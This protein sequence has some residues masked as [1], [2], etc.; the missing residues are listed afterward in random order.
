MGSKNDEDQG[1]DFLK[2]MRALEIISELGRECLGLVENLSLEENEFLKRR[3]QL[4]R[5]A[6]SPTF[7]RNIS[8]HRTRLDY[9]GQPAKLGNIKGIPQLG[10]AWLKKWRQRKEIRAIGTRIVDVHIVTFDEGNEIAGDVTYLQSHQYR[11]TSLFEL[12][13]FV[14]DNP[15]LVGHNDVLITLEEVTTGEGPKQR[16][17]MYAHCINR[18][19][20]DELIYKMHDLRTLLEKQGK[21]E[22]PPLLHYVVM[23]AEDENNA[24]SGVDPEPPSDL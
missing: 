11:M 8:T 18:S 10:R 16:T 23:D 9:S 12:L 3:L 19:P 13:C 7:K 5:Q 2:K 20:K 6:A 14:D 22:K 21:E 1:T 15:A 4:A 24:E 17:A